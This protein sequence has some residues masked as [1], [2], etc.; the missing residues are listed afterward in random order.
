MHAST[1]HRV[2]RERAMPRTGIRNNARRHRASDRKVHRSPC[3]ST[4]PPMRSRR[5]IALALA[6]GLAL[7][8]RMGAPDVRED[9]RSR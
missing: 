2:R 3:M 5:N 1:A 6:A 9:R 4:R 8:V 7:A